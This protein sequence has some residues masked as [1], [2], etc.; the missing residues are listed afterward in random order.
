MPTSTAFVVSCQ[1]R[2]ALSPLLAAAGMTSYRRAYPHLVQLHITRE[3]EQGGIWLAALSRH[4]EESVHFA[5]QPRFI[6]HASWY[7]RVTSGLESLV[8]NVPSDPA[9]VP[10]FAAPPHPSVH[11]G[12]WDARFD[13][14]QPTLAAR[15]PVLAARRAVFTLA[16]QWLRQAVASSSAL[17]PDGMAAAKES[18][19]GPVQAALGSVVR[20]FDTLRADVEGL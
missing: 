11:L 2:E 20:A 13:C 5:V 9:S 6:R 19:K 17:L 14:L 12:E 8:E 3:V 18:A 10:S 15:E 4:I 16:T 7:N 1:V